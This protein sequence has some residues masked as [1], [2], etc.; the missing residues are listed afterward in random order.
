MGSSRQPFSPLNWWE[1]LGSE[2]YMLCFLRK[3]HCFQ[4]ESLEILLAAFFEAQR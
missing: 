3:I 1:G 4:Q 2:G